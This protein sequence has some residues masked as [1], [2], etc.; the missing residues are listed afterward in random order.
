[1]YHLKLVRLVTTFVHCSRH[2][3]V[4]CCKFET[5][6]NKQSKLNYIHTLRSFRVITWIMLR[7]DIFWESRLTTELG[8]CLLTKGFLL[9][10]DDPPIFLPWIKQTGYCSRIIH[11]FYF[12][13]FW[14]FIFFFFSIYFFCADPWQ[15]TCFHFFF[16]FL[17]N[18]FYCYPTPNLKCCQF[19][20][21]TP[22][23]ASNHI[24]S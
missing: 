2:M 5:I 14:I 6:Q 19:Q 22:N 10:I 18:K 3:N 15:S 4:P 23:L 1:M 21:V 20:I 17:I 13:C 9:N 24:Q 16:L 8:V 7:V 12:C 11:L